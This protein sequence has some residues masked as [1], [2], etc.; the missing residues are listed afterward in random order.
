M[1]NLN[2]KVSFELGKKTK[3]GAK[4]NTDNKKQGK[5]KGGDSEHPKTWDP[6]RKY[7]N[8]RATSGIGVER[9]QAEN[10][11]SGAHDPK[12]CKDAAAKATT[13]KR[14]GDDKKNKTSNAKKLKVAR[15]YVAKLE[16]RSTDDDTSGNETE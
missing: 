1:K 4:S 15:A 10:A 7:R 5:S 12:E 14:G 3:V 16:Q 2:K 9:R 8:T 6:A 13:G 11:K